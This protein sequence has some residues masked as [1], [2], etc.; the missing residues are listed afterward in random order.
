MKII[1]L[2]MILL[3]N[4]YALSFNEYK[5]MCENDNVM[6]SAISSDN[7]TMSN[8][9][10]SAE[11]IAS[12]KLLGVELSSESSLA[13]AYKKLNN[14]EVLSE[15]FTTVIKTKAN[16]IIFPVTAKKTKFFPNGKGK[17]L[18]YA[19]A[20]MKKNCNSVKSYKEFLKVFNN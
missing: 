6:V 8:A 7:Q 19:E 16:G 10:A 4:I 15:D 13:R 5:Q 11:I 9:I 1:L 3:I 14:T 12:Q 2:Q 17:G 20:Y 18:G